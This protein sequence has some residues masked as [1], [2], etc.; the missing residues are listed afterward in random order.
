[1]TEGWWHGKEDRPRDHTD[2]TRSGT[3]TL[4][5]PGSPSGRDRLAAPVDPRVRQCEDQRSLTNQAFRAE[6]ALMPIG[7]SG[8]AERFASRDEQ[9]GANP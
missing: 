1:V 9:M 4:L 8:R 5:V 2:F 6:R 3:I 7:W